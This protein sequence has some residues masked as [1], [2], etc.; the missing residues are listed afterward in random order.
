VEKIF[1]NANIYTT[2]CEKL[3]KNVKTYTT[4]EGVKVNDLASSTP[5]QAIKLAL[6]LAIGPGHKFIGKACSDYIKELQRLGL[7]SPYSFA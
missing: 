6:F 4:L 3:F 2:L 7:F 1:P 5:M